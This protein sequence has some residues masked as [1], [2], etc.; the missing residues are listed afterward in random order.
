MENLYTVPKPKNE[1]KELEEIYPL[2]VLGIII[3]LVIPGDREDP[4]K[5]GK[6]PV[7]LPGVSSLKDLL[8][9]PV[10]AVKGV[11]MKNLQGLLGAEMTSEGA[12]RYTF[13]DM[14]FDIA[15]SIA[16]RRLQPGFKLYEYD[17]LEEFD[18]KQ[19]VRAVR[20]DERLQA[21]LAATEVGSAF[22][23]K[24]NIQP[25]LA[26]SIEGAALATGRGLAPRKGGGP[27]GLKPPAENV[28]RVVVGGLGDLERFTSAN[29]GD[30]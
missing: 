19:L 17:L 3:P 14:A 2:D 5:T 13:D 1:V 8:G 6:A 7:K 27:L 26:V 12:Q 25:S 18:R 11:V 30:P 29:P 22:L 4:A 21:Q 15:R 10:N 23:R 28:S 24:A 16:N 20:A 9:G